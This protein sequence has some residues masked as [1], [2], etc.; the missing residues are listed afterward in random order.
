MGVK[1]ERLRRRVRL[2]SNLKFRGGEGIEEEREASLGRFRPR[3][4][5]VL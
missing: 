5:G 2:E 1:C 4:G 3:G